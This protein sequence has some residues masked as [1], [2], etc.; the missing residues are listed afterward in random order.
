MEEVGAY[1]F[2]P[3]LP[4]LG[5]LRK[6]CLMNRSSSSRVQWGFSLSGDLALGK[7]RLGSSGQ[8][9]L[10]DAAPLFGV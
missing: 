7:K 3:G 8:T 10:L 1:C 4:T 9:P 5:G 6:T 2:L